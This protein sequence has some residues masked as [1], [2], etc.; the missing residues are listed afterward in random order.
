MQLFDLIKVMFTDPRAYSGISWNDRAKNMFMVQRIMSITFPSA[1]Q[2]FNR[3][4][5]NP[6]GVVDHWQRQAAIHGRV[7]GWVFTKTKKADKDKAW[8]PDKQAAL[9]WMR[10]NQLGQRDLDMAIAQDPVAMKE[11]LQSI[12]KT[13]KP[14]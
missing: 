14:E 3:V 5:T 11:L 10:H 7:P 2:A 12:T 1:A 9:E 8:V 4:G 13:M 6:A